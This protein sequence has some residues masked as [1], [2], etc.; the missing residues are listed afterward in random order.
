MR[1]TMREYTQQQRS[2]YLVMLRAQIRSSSQG[3]R[4]AAGSDLPVLHHPR[5]DSGQGRP[6][7]PRRPGGDLDRNRKQKRKQRAVAVGGDAR[8]AVRR[9]NT[10]RAERGSSDR[11]RPTNTTDR[12]GRLRLPPTQLR[13]A[14]L[15]PGCRR[16]RILRPP[17][18]RRRQIC[19]KY[20][21]RGSGSVGSS[22][23]NCFR[24]RQ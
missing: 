6:V 7:S 15:Q 24:L 22:A 2:A 23:S 20:W 11:A 13:V 5:L 17:R 8:V 1:D 16:R 4:A 3:R 10:G 9:R 21:K 18:R 14:R 19:P 12:A